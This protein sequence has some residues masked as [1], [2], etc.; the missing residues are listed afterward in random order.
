MGFFRRS[1]KDRIARRLHVGSDVGPILS[2]LFD[3]GRESFTEDNTPTL[4]AWLFE[5]LIKEG[6]KR[7]LPLHTMQ[8]LFDE[9][10]EGAFNKCQKYQ[11]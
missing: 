10:I 7:D 1:L 4:F 11:P 8:S 3:A 9:E 2:D 5:Y 6:M